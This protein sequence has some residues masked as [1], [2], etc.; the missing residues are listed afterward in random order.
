M[1]ATATDLPRRHDFR[2]YAR[3]LR[4]LAAQKRQ[5]AYAYL[6][7]LGQTVI[8]LVIPQLVKWIVDAGIGDEP[9]AQ[10]LPRALQGLAVSRISDQKLDIVIW[11]ITLLILLSL[12]RGYF[13][14]LSGV[15]SEEMSQGTAFSLRNQLYQNLSH[16]SFHFHD[17]SKAGDLLAR[18]TQDVERL[19]FLCGRATLGIVNALVL[20]VA[21][22]T[23]LFFM[24]P[25]LALLSMAVIPVLIQ[26]AWAFGRRYRPLSQQL[27]EQLGILTT[28]LE[29]N[30]RGIKV[31]KAFARED[32]QVEN[33]HKANSIWFDVS[34]AA[35]RTRSLRIPLLDLISGIGTV[36][37]MYA[38]GRAVIN[39]TITLGDLL[40]FITY[41]GQLIMPIRRL[42]MIIPF[43]AMAS[44]ASERVFEILDKKSAISET[45]EAQT[46]PPVQ[47]S[48]AFSHVSFNYTKSHR[49]LTDISFDLAPGEVLALLG[50]TGSGKS[51]LINLIPRFYDPSQG[52]IRIDGIDIRDVT[53]HSLR[54]QIAIVLQDPLLFATS[55]RENIAFGL[56]HATDDE[57]IEAARAAQAHDFIMEMPEQ[58]D[59]Q[60]GE[61]GSTLSG[62]QRQRI[63]IARALITN[64]GILILDDATSSVDTETEH[65]IQAALDRLM[66]NRT[67]IVIAQRLSTVRKASRILLLEK[68]RMSA[69]GTHEEL[70]HQSALYRQIY[71]GQLQS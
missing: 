44:A 61:K 54:H 50:P 8:A 14:Y 27:Q 37:V 3:P 7:M 69:L 62:G 26:Q 65:Q 56:E 70:W 31:V 20:M 28:H 42:G 19:R 22:A 23:V 35:V 12:V 2:L 10:G 24:N 38:G 9:L 25:Q 33:F 67:S 5:V 57:V 51:T 60:V 29:Q 41:L 53:L 71:R 21:T 63:S 36:I 15:N 46:L 59:T 52:R 16:L 43:V 18:A 55:I 45:P 11:S 49:V 34:A 48:L 4:Y 64:P 66:A 1:T 58:Y 32:M 6:G 30:L 68:G 39:Q 47:G 17:T 40:A 13:I